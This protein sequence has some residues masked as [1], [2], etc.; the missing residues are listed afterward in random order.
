MVIIKR[1][2][3]VL[4]KLD[5]KCFLLM[6][7]VGVFIERLGLYQKEKLETMLLQNVTTHIEF[8]FL[9]FKTKE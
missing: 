7:N 5:K 3:L 4:E 9:D 1:K 6:R 2:A 8:K